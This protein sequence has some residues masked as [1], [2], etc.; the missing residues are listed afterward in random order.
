MSIDHFLGKQS[1]IAWLLDHHLAEHAG[2]DHLDVLVGD[3]DALGTVD[4]LHLIEHVGEDGFL[5]LN[6]EDFLWNQWTFSQ[7]ITC[8]DP[9]ATVDKQVLALRDMMVGFVARVGDDT[10]GHLALSQVVMQFDATGDRCHDGRILGHPG[11]EDLR[12]SRQTTDDVGRTGN[13]LRLT[14]KHLALENFLAFL[15]FDTCLGRQVMEVENLA[16]GIFHQDL[17]MHLAGVFDDDELL[18]A[19][20]LDGFL[21]DRL[22]DLDVLESDSTG[23]FR[24][25]RCSVGIPVEQ[26]LALA[27]LLAVADPDD[28]TVWNLFLLQLT[29]LG[30]QD[31]DLTV[32]L[33]RDEMLGAFDV[34]FDFV[35]VTQLDGAA[36]RRLEAG[37]DQATRCDAARVEGTHGEL[38]A[39]FADGLCGNRADGQ[40]TFDGHAGGHVHAVA[41]LAD[42]IGG[43]AGKRC[44]DMDRIDSETFDLLGDLAGDHL[45]LG[46][47]GLVRQRVDDRLTARSAE[48]DLS[49]WDIDFLA[50]VDR[51]LGQA[52]LGA[53]ILFRDDHG[54]GDVV[55][56]SCEVSG[57][58]RLE[59]GIGQSLSGTVSGGE[60]LENVQ[61][62]A[63]VRSDGRLDDF[64]T[65][66]GHQATHA[67]ELLHLADVASSTGCRHEVHRVEVAFAFCGI[68]AEFVQV[69][70]VAT[71]VLE[72]RDQ[73][74]REFLT[75]MRPDVQQLVVAFTFGDRTGVECT[76]DTI[77]LQLCRIQKFRLAGRDSHVGDGD[78]QTR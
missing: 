31:D 4:V 73:F 61:A 40:A 52:S 21:A 50:F 16:F 6:V 29:V 26:G 15:H 66:L 38:G 77:H 62:F 49:Q 36:M 17:R 7:R 67:G 46:N 25:N 57:V 19:T 64:T 42:T 63:E 12:D 44:S 10:D 45:V 70:Q 59:C 34:D 30:I 41:V 53:A 54:L 43:L 76:L 8:I 58:R 39:R 3:G 74:L 47:D 9:V 69:R 24:K 27:D 55:E 71:I 78:R 14:C 2:E 35:A 28:G 1:G 33:Q 51:S 22:A 23:L 18:L 11:L 72:G 48:D 37:V 5:A 56:L 32:S 60:V 65:R 68:D 75:A 13:I 20:T